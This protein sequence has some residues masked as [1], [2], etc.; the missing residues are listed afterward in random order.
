MSSGSASASPVAVVVT[1]RSFGS[2]HVD[3]AAQLR[4]R[5][6]DVVR[7]DPRHDPE[8][9]REVLSTAFGWVAGT[10]PIGP[11]QLDL[12]PVL[13]VIARYGVGTDAV[14]VAAAASRGIVVANTP[15]A[16]SEAVADHA[17]ALMLAALRHVVA[18]DL[19]ARAGD[20]S[21]RP[22][23]ELSAITVGI[24]GFGRVGRAL[25]RRLTGGFGTRVLVHDPWLEAAAVTR[26]GC[27]PVDLQ[28]LAAASDAISLHVPGGERP[29]VDGALLAGI[30][31]GAVLVNTARGDLI[32][33]RAVAAALRD[34][35][36]GAAA[37]DV[38]ATEPARASPLLDAPNVT[39]TP[40]VAAQTSE[41]IDRMGTMAVQSILRV[42][43]GEPPAHPVLPPLEA[44]TP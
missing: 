4:K 20:W 6:L 18:G 41:A 43:D 16:N 30:R 21:A 35:T 9:L 10:G 33:E 19:A 14:D 13:R 12:A 27:E 28:T 42:L 1:S 15:G 34:G 24:V 32:D 2:G 5:G 36:L 39:V 29:I 23:R 7:A 31:R 11:A 8:A 38:L 40:H 44:S 37:V 25:A 26:A 17:L 22:G 3:P